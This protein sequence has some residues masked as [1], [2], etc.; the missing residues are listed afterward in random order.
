MSE[1]NGSQ[2]IASQKIEVQAVRRTTA[3]DEGKPYE[4]ITQICIASTPN[5]YYVAL[6]QDVAPTFWAENKEEAVVRLVA[7]LYFTPAMI[8]K[9]LVALQDVLN[10]ENAVVK[11]D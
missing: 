11:D 5:G 9:L 1:S 8:E 7:K 4:H 3:E 6:G 2:P 10:R